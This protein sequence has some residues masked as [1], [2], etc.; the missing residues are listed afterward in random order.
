[1][2][3]AQLNLIVIDALSKAFGGCSI[4]ELLQVLQ[5]VHR[6]REDLPGRLKHSRVPRLQP[7]E[8]V[9]ELGFSLVDGSLS[10]E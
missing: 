2:V 3:L 9:L 10:F 4:F 5:A 1:M 6:N 8:V 7:S